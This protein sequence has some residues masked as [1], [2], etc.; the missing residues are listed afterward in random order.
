MSDNIYRPTEYVE[1]IK[2]YI[3]WLLPEFFKTMGAEASSVNWPVVTAFGDSLDD[4]RN[5]ILTCDKMSFINTSEGIY[6]DRRGL[7][8]HT[9]RIVNETDEDY[10]VRLQNAIDTKK[11][12][13]TKIGMENGLSDIGFTTSV[14]EDYIGLYWWNRY[15]IQIT[16]WDGSYPEHQFFAIVKKLNPG[17]GIPVFEASA[18]TATFDDWTQNSISSFADAGSG[19]VTVGFGLAAHLVLDGEMVEIYGTINYDGIYT[20]EY[21]NGAQFNIIHS[22]DGDDATGNIQQLFD[23]WDSREEYFDDWNPTP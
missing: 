4:A 3:W 22:W 2:T 10:I 1:N 5:A 16:A 6:L 21:V 14:L 9:P 15:T 20:V 13:G 7:D 18:I 8:R 19:K 23:D 11:Q 17:H 12:A